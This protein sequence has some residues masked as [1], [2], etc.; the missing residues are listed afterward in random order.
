MA[1]GLRMGPWIPV[2][3]A[4]LIF[5]VW[6]HHLQDARTLLHVSAKS[7]L[8]TLLL[9]ALML[10][11]TYGGYALL[12]GVPF[13]G[14]AVDGL[15][16]WAGAMGPLQWVLLPLVMACEEVMWRGALLTSLTERHGAVRGVVFC[17]LLYAVAHVGSLEPVLVGVALL[18]GLGWG[19]LR[20]FSKSVLASYV[21]HA[22]WDL[23][24]LLWFP[25]VHV[26]PP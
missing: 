21:C 11:C 8:A 25:L 9:T 23:S 19:A 3:V 7:L 15:Y 20:I 12:H 13:V 16:A 22:L 10:A 24:I 5:A 26:P 6:S 1:A 14:A 2:A 17:A 4:G 18:C